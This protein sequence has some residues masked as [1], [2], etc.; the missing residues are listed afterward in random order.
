MS[1]CFVS[2]HL[3]DAVLSSAQTISQHPAAHVLTVFTDAPPVHRT[4]GWNH[5]TTA[6]DYAPDTQAIRRAEDR[7][8]LTALGATAHWLGLHE[9]EYRPA[10][11]S[12]SDVTAEIADAIAAFLAEHPADLV[13]APLG[14]RHPDHIAVADACLQLV[15]TLPV[16][17]RLALDQ[18]Y[19][20]TF[21]DLVE[22]RLARARSLGLRVTELDPTPVDATTKATAVASYATQIDAVRGEHPLLDLALEAD[23]RWWQ[24]GIDPG[25]APIA[26]PAPLQSA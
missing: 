16:R 19:G 22:E 6:H 12:P 5:A 14:L 21:P 17:W 13:V 7:A 26:E 24:V 15:G 1:I 4:D 25:A 10:D 8:A 3:D 23:E 2:P 20:T 11:R 18:P 9:A